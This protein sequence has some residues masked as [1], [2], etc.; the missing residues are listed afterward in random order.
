M[1][2]FPYPRTGMVTLMRF[3]LKRSAMQFSTDHGR[4]GQDHNDTLAHDHSRAEGT[5]SARRAIGDLGEGHT[6]ILHSYKK[7]Y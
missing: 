7:P 3:L 4:K 5:L 2:E 6:L 1:A